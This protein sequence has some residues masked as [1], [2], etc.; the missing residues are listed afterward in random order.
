M[1]AAALGVLVASKAYGVTR[2]AAVPRLLPKDFTLVKE[3]GEWKIS[4]FGGGGSTPPPDG[5]DGSGG[6]GGTA[7]TTPETTPETTAPPSDGGGSGGSGSGSVPSEALI[8]AE[9]E[10]IPVAE[11]CAAG[12]M[13]ACDTL[14]RQTPTGSNIEAKT[15]LELAKVNHIVAVKEASGNLAQIADILRGRPRAFSV[16]SGDDEFTMSLMALGGDVRLFAKP[17]TRKNRRMGVALARG[18][19]VEEA[20]ESARKAAAQVRIVYS[21]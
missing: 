10:D 3:D 9:P 13:A 17:V 14:W 2:A 4:G 7:S 6:G 18:E 11:Q 20:R 16:L 21:S 12:D 15:T 1:F 8:D 5:G 19:T